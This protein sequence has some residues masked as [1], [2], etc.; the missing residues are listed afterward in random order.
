MNAR[1]TRMPG[2]RSIGSIF[3]VLLPIVS[4]AACRA[5]APVAPLPPAPPSEPATPAVAR[6]PTWVGEPLSWAKLGAIET[7]LAT[8]GV[9]ADPF[10]RV[11]GEI[12]L[13]QGRVDLAR[14]E[15]S[16]QKA[17]DAASRSRLHASRAGF[18]HVLA[19]SDA[20]PE[21][22]K[23]AEAAI[24]ICDRMLGT[25]P[26]SSAPRAAL[27][28]IPRS[29]WGAMTAIAAHMDKNRGGWRR[30][31]V[32]HSAERVPPELDGTFAESAAAVRSIQKAHMEGK[33]TGYGDI[34]YHFVIDPYGRVFQGRDLAWQGAHAA[35]A[36][37]VQNIG[38]CL[39]GNFD[40]EKPTKA[41][42]DRLR[43]LLDNLRST[44]KIPRSQV[45][46]HQELKSTECPG[47]N[48]ARWVEA[49]RHT[50]VAPVEASARAN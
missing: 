18:Q 29:Q 42:L 43:Q 28:I 11:E 1:L 45:F 13:H 39:I 47:R 22:K 3:L 15:K 33:E 4:F 31:T 27:P 2:R 41:A 40:E 36:N 17:T 30:M 49:Y 37:N 50:A 46:T 21:Q 48:L 23:R 35:G 25:T 44:W 20:T 6:T 24:Q 26:A 16:G 8:D 7:W 10:W 9:T 12:A 32:H 34:G 14:A 5:V 19:E 38:I